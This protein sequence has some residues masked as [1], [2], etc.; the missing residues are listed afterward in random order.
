MDK[1]LAEFFRPEELSEVFGQE[2]LTGKDKIID[3]MLKTHN[4][5]NMIFY[6]PPGIGKTTVANII[7]KKINTRIHMFNATYTKTEEIKKVINSYREGN[8]E[9][10]KPIIYVDEIQN[11]NKKQQQIFLEF[12]EDGTITFIGATTENPNHYVYKA[13]LSRCIILEYY[14]IDKKDIIKNLEYTVEKLNRVY[15]K[16][17]Q[18]DDDAKDMIA[19]YADMDMRRSIY[20]LDII[21]SLYF[22]DENEV[23]IDKEILKTLGISKQFAYDMKSD[24]YYDLLSAFQKSI[25]GS[26]ENAALFYLA[27]MIKAGDIKPVCRRLM[28]IAAEDIGMAFPNVI[29]IVKSCVDC[30]L[31]LGLPEARLPLAEAA[32]LLATSPKSNSV[33][34]AIDSALHSIG[35]KGVGKIPNDLKDAHYTLASQMGRGVGYKYPH[36][37]KNN[38]VQ[39]Q[40]LPNEHKDD[41]YYTPQNNKYESEIKRYWKDIKSKEK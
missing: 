21:I 32:I 28:V 24:E 34:L 39:Q 26:D 33:I 6:G 18:L 19:D 14:K 2:H 3:R 4:T 23:V 12:I 15:N 8:I 38:Y 11:F 36:N 41:I 29:S 27:R 16:K 25:R 1:P 40:Y 10:I 30:A 5:L 17:F 20:L 31:E 22:E 13:L 37:Y 9:N 7:A 35:E